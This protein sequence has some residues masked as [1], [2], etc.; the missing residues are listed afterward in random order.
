[1]ILNTFLCS[2]WQGYRVF[3]TW[4]GDPSKVIL[5]EEMVKVIKDWR[6]LENAATVGDGIVNSLTRLQVSSSVKRMSDIGFVWY[7]ILVLI[8][9]MFYSKPET[10]V[11]VTDMMIYDWSLVIVYFFISC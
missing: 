7:Q 9:S 10:D 5:L 8:R 6:L 4:M 11:H 1:M 2:V 3:N